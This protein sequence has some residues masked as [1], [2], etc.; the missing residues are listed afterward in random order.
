MS[1]ESSSGAPVVG[2]FVTC[3]VN[4]IRPSVGFAALELLERAGCKVEIPEGQT[5][6]GLPGFNAGDIR[7]TRR[8]AQ[9]VVRIF[10]P[11]EYVVVPSGSCAAMISRSYHEHVFEGDPVWRKRAEA[12]G[13]K[14]FELTSFLFDV[15][16]FS[17][18]GPDDD[19]G[20]IKATYHDSCSCLRRLGIRS[21]PRELIKGIGRVE[22]TEMENGYECC[23]FG[24]SFS[25][26][27][28]EIAARMAKQKIDHAVETGADTILGADLGCLIH[29]AYH[30]RQKG[31][32]L[33]VRHVAEVLAGR[34][35]VPTI[36]EER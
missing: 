6:C 29:L 28:P 13:R 27:M 16:H 9:R 35:K 30:I 18:R 21:Q 17:Q 23:G 1:Q 3:L 4:M 34:T 26:K 31:L 24:G 25:L 36:G 22:L 15:M 20:A 19:Q 5:C 32:P 2:L 14:T 11:Y 8:L 7:G 12:L 10:E 33:K